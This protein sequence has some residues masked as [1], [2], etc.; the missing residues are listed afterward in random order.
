[1]KALAKVLTVAA[2]TCLTGACTRTYISTG[3]PGVPSTEGGT[4]RVCWTIHGA[5]GRSYIDKNKKLVDVCIKC[6]NQPEPS[7][8]LLQRFKFVA[9]DLEVYVQWLS[10]DEV[11]IE[12]HDYGDGVSSYDARKTGASSNHL[13]TLIFC[14]DKKSGKFLEKK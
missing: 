8:L 9:S 14:S 4:T 10:P 3:D 13:R 12:F 5:Y 1:M 6:G 11:S 2:L 7:I